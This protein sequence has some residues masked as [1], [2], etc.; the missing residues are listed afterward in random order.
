[1]LGRFLELSVPAPEILASWIFYQKLGFA[2]APVGETWQHRYAVATDGRIAIGLHDSSL[3]APALSY[4]LP[5]LRTQIPRLESV[6]I[7]VIHCT[8][9]DESF[10]TA[11][12]AG[13]DGLDLRIVEARTFSPADQPKPSVLGWFEEC[14]LPVANLEQAQHS[15]EQLGFVAVAMQDSPWPNVGLTS[16]TLNL[17]LY[18]TRELSLPTLRFSHDDLPSLRTQLNGLGIEVSRRTPRSLD[19]A[20]YLL[21]T[22]PEGM[23]LLIGPPPP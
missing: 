5:G 1:M 19:P 18:E 3:E 9:G 15:W 11:D 14:A 20:A 22:S 13:P 6:G 21:L 10:N 17:G 4:V 8:L 23:N 12:F 7:A 16:D 2:S